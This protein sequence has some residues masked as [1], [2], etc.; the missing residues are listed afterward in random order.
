ME[1]K[2]VDAEDGKQFVFDERIFSVTKLKNGNIEWR[3]G[4][5]NWYEEE[6]TVKES[7]Q[8]LEEIKTFIL[9]ENHNDN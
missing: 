5:D 2:I 8:L 3:E 1:T 6:I 4:C 9:G 7:L